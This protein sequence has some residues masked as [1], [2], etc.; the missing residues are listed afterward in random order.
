MKRSLYLAV[1]AA[2]CTSLLIFSQTPASA[3]T[4]VLPSLLAFPEQ[5][6]SVTIPTATPTTAEDWTERGLALFQSRNYDEAIQAYNQAIRLDH[7]SAAAYAGRALVYYCKGNMELAKPAAKDTTENQDYLNALSD[8]NLAIALNPAE[9]SYR[10]GR[11]HVYMKLSRSQDALADLNTVVQ[12]RPDDYSAYDLRADVYRELKLYDLAL[13]DLD[14]ALS[15]NS[16]DPFNSFARGRI[17]AAREDY[18]HALLYYEQA[19]SKD[20][21]YA[22]AWFQKGIALE[23]LGRNDEAIAAYRQ[24]LHLD[25][26]HNPENVAYAVNHAT[27]LYHPIKK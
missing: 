18:T 26:T 17:Y 25:R 22:D 11:V 2:F 27:A 21:Q 10:L 12:D 23:A 4:N 5:A 24:F 14:R 9:T 13:A 8:Y 6:I 1:S 16:R 15:L 19:L 20:P 7:K 3:Q